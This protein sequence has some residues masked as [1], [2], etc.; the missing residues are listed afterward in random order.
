MLLVNTL[1]MQFQ[2][3][4]SKRVITFIECELMNYGIR[5][6]TWSHFAYVKVM[7]YM[8]EFSIEILRLIILQ[9]CLIGTEKYKRF[10]KHEF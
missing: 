1:A 3:L 8:L 9:N 5:T 7:S 2:Y 10:L 6:I 4:T